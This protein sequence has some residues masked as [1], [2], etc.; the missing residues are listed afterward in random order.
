MLTPV[1]GNRPIGWSGHGRTQSTKIEFGRGDAQPKTWIGRERERI[2]NPPLKF[3]SGVG[4]P[5]LWSRFA[6]IS[7]GGSGAGKNRG[8]SSGGSGG[9]G[10]DEEEGE[11]RGAAQLAAYLYAAL[12]GVG[13]LVGYIKKGSKYSLAAGLIFALLMSTCG[14]VMGDPSNNISVWAAIVLSGALFY[15]M[16]K[17]YANSKKI[18]PAGLTAGVSFVMVFFYSTLAL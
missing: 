11:G 13:G 7:G 2:F 6:S 3:P 10:G 1:L 5:S 17:R 15:V 12:V 14:F 8:G 9:D 18:M 16:G 4:S